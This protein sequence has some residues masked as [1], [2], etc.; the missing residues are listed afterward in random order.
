M[1]PLVDPRERY[2]LKEK[3][4]TGA[5]GAVYRAVEIATGQVVAAKIID[6][7]Q[8]EDEMQDIQQ[9]RLG[10]CVTPGVFALL[11]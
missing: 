8:A 3:I 9:V 1:Q 5:F 7:D 11:G 2:E 10:R 6:V 4:G